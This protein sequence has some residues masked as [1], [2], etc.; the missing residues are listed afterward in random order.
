MGIPI[1]PEWYKW[2]DEVEAGWYG[3]YGVCS[4]A[5]FDIDYLIEKARLSKSHIACINF[6]CF[7]HFS[8]RRLKFCVT[9]LAFKTGVGFDELMSL[10]RDTQY[11]LKPESITRIANFFGVEPK[12]LITMARLNESKQDQKWDEDPIQFLDNIGTIEKLNP[13]E[14][15]TLDGLRSFLLRQARKSKLDSAA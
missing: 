15:A 5:P 14:N 13:F 3:N 4:I 12:G 9:E 8:R 10:E 2:A 7:V 1:T 6:Y 11:K